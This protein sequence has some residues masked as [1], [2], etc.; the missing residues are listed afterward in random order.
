M[1]KVIKT[2]ALL[3]TLS[4]VNKTHALPTVETLTAET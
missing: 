2:S 1:M 3:D 4:G